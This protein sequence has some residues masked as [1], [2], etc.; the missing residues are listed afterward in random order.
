MPTAGGNFF[1][2]LSRGPT[3]ITGVNP[4][5]LFSLRILDHPLDHLLRRAEVYVLE[6]MARPFRRT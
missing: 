5:S 6:Y 1:V 3:G 2:Q 4:K